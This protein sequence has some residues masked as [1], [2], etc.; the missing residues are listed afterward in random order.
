MSGTQ[1]AGA[2]LVYYFDP[3]GE[4]TTLLEARIISSRD[5]GDALGTSVAG[6]RIG[7]RDVIAAGA[8]GLGSF[9]LFYCSTLGGEG[10]NSSRCQ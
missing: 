5:G 7:S 4:K 3:E 8:P 6:L 2:V 10:R 1:N 9:F